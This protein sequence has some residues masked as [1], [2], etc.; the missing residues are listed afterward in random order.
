MIDEHLQLRKVVEKKAAA[1][2]RPLDAWMNNASIKQKMMGLVELTKCC[3]YIAM[4]LKS[5]GG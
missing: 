3:I 1:G 4:V 2:R 5:S